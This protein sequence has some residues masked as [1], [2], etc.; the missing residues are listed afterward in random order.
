MDNCHF[1]RLTDEIINL[2]QPYSC[3]KD[4]DIDSF[5]HKDTKDNFSDY[6]YEMMGNSHCFYTD[7]DSPKMVCAFSLSN[8]AL[9]T[10]LL[11]KRKRN[12]FNKTI[13]NAKRRSQYPAILIGQLCVFDGFG[14]NSIQ[15]SVADEMMNLIKT[16]A[17]R[18]NDSAIRYLVV[19]AVNN[20]NV[21]NYYKR[22]GFA[23]LFESDEEELECLRSHVANKSIIRRIKDIC[24]PSNKNEKLPCRTRLMYFD[25][26]L[27]KQ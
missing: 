18:P 21:I 22:N 25:L 5:F 8:S 17:I 12:R 24:C 16:M 10:D 3:S 2:C 7:E 23:F 4:S 20:E 19:D 6:S 13:P 15:E 14:H 9:R 27:L 26:V 11:P 1:D